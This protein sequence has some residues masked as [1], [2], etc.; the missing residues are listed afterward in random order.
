MDVMIDLETLGTRP[1]AAIIQVGAVMFEARDRGR[2]LNGKGFNRHVLVQDGAGTIDHSTIA[3][4]LQEKSAAKMGRALAERAEPLFAVLSAL[5]QWPGEVVEGM[6]WDQV[7]TVWS[8]GAAFDQP[9]LASA[10]SKMGRNPPWH[11]RASRCC[12]TLFDLAGGAPTIDWTGLTPHDALDD[13]IGQAM[14]VQSAM[15]L[16]RGKF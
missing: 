12:R 7:E 6:T 13:S 5:E 8:N 11:Y 1:D 10:Y 4:W 15:A 16:L 3:F 14:Q 2:I 9:I